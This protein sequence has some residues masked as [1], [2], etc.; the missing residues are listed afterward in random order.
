MISFKGI[1]NFI[2]HT[3]PDHCHGENPISILGMMCGNFE[4]KETHILPLL[5]CAIVLAISIKFAF[6]KLQTHKWLLS[7]VHISPN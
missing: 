4:E 3:Y 5:C 7:C 6:V 1:Q 2:D